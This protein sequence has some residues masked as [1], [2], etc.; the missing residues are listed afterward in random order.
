M[1]TLRVISVKFLG[2]ICVWHFI[3]HQFSNLCKY[4]RVYLTYKFVIA[5]FLWLETL[6]IGYS[7]KATHTCHSFI[8]TNC[9]SHGCTSHTLKQ[10]PWIPSIPSSLLAS[11]RMLIMDYII[12]KVTRKWMV[13]CDSNV[14]STYSNCFH[15]IINLLTDQKLRLWMKCCCVD[16][17]STL[18]CR[19]CS[20]SNN[21]KIF[22]SVS[23]KHVWHKPIQ[24]S[25]KAPHVDFIL[26]IACIKSHMPPQKK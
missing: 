20:P 22:T 8:S 21:F 25:C 6:D 5:Y 17:K 10:S 13:S 16:W 4:L 23:N 24:T 26:I 15:D 3:I 18:F 12:G 2:Y 7:F 19:K 14:I 9:A 11:M 1:S